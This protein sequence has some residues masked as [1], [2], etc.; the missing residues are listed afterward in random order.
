ML[1]IY[2]ERL[3]REHYQ[4]LLAVA[5]APQVIRSQRLFIRKHPV[6]TDV[7]IRIQW[8]TSRGGFSHYPRR[9]NMGVYLVES[10]QL[11]EVVSSLSQTRSLLEGKSS[12]LKTTSQP[13]GPPG[14]VYFSRCIYTSPISRPSR[15][16]NQPPT[17]PR[18]EEFNDTTRRDA[19]VLLPNFAYTFNYLTSPESPE[20][21]RKKYCS[22]KLWND[23][24]VL[25]SAGFSSERRTEGC[26]RVH[27]LFQT[28]CRDHWESNQ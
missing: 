16:T 4:I 1:K 3:R 24:A 12:S 13:L 14:H 2:E 6:Y 23:A 21:H 11:S 15:P 10:W 28:L 17:L 26:K 25:V 20:G 22:P 27:E 5:Q 9:H 18:S 7:Y 8:T 19:T